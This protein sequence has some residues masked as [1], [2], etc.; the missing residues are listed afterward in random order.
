MV[1]VFFIEI[2]CRLP[3]F[4]VR[5]ASLRYNVVD[6]WCMFFFSLLAITR[7]FP[8]HASKLIASKL[9]ISS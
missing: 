7:L 5:V 9:F 6:V 3:Y 1:D 4:N 8:H 2:P